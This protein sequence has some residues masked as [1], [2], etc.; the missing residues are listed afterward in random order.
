[1]HN[2]KC[3]SDCPGCQ[4]MRENE[5]AR[6]LIAKIRGLEKFQATSGCRQSLALHSE[7]LK[8]IVD[9]IDNGSGKECPIS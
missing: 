8:A 2:G 4:T 3:A 5:I 6:I 7:E 1:M 9:F